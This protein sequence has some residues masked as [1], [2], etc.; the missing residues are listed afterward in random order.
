MN[1]IK[2]NW[3]DPVWSKVFASLIVSALGLIALIVKSIYEN[4]NLGIVFKNAFQYLIRTKIEISLIYILL[5]VFILFL[6]SLPYIIRLFKR[7]KKSRLLKIIEGQ[8]QLEYFNTPGQTS[9]EPVYFNSKFEYYIN[10][11]LIYLLKKIFYEEKT[12][13]IE[14]IKF[15]ISTQKKHSI[16][17][18]IIII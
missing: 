14:W 7:K 13:T 15:R 5:I 8:W 1:W 16:E 6:I 18:L 3:A 4:I 17:K 2:K 11:D 9:F 10:H 12:Q